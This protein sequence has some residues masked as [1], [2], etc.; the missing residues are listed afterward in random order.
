MAIVLIRS[1]LYATLV[2][3]VLAPELKCLDANTLQA[4]AR[5]Y[6]DAQ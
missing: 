1:M 3:V 2:H 5:L 6:A 4:H